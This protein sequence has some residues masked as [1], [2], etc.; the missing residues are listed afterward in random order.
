MSE[1]RP[2]LAVEGI[3]K[4]FPGVQA[5]RD[6][7]FDVFPGEILG[8]VGENGAGKSTLMRILSGVYQPDTG[9]IRF[10]GK[11]VRIQS[12]AQAQRLGISMVYQDTRL[13]SDLDIVQNV[14]LGNEP[15][16]FLGLINRTELDH[17]TIA[18][19]RQLGVSL[20]P[21]K[22][23]SGLS[24]AER[25]IVELARALK[26]EASVLILD[27]PTSALD[28]AEVERLFSILRELRHN[29]TGI[30]FISHRLQEVEELTDR[31]TVLR[32]GE[33]V[34]TLPTSSTAQEQLVGLMV[35]Q[36]E[37]SVAFPAKDTEKGSV[38]L[39]VR[40]LTSP[41]LFESISFNVSRGEIVGFGGI[42][43]EGQRDIIRALFGL[44]PATGN[45]YVDGEPVSLRGPA[46]AIS[47]GIVYLS[48]DRR[49]ESLMMPHSI[50]E[51]VVLPH[52]HAWSRAGV[53]DAKREREAVAATI[54]RLRI[55]TPSAEQPVELL[56]GGNQQKVVI[57]RWLH[58]APLVYIFDE[59]TQGVDVGT[60]LELYR[61]IRQLAEDG[62]AVLFLSSE[63]T[64]LLGVCD[65]IVVVADGR[66]VNTVVSDDAVEEEIIGSAVTATRQDVVRDETH[67]IGTAGRASGAEWILRRWGSPLF[68]VLLI[69]GL[70]V[71]TQFRS[72]YFLTSSNLSD[73]AIQVVPLA[74]VAMGQ[75]AVI[76]VGGIDLAV[77]PTMSLTT[78]I[79]SHW[80]V[81]E[82][83]GSILLGTLACVLA[84]AAVGLA[85]GLLIHY[86]R[87]P[88][89]LATLATYSVVFGLALVVRPSPGGLVSF[90]F[91]D[92]VTQRVHWI[93]IIALVTLL[94]YVVGEVVLVQTRPGIALY[95]TGSTPEA[96]F[97]AGVPVERVR[98]ASYVFCGL[99][100]ALAGLVIAARI[101][102]GDPQSG[103]SFTLASITAVVVGGTSIFGGRGTLV[104]TLAGSI[105]V[106]E[107]QNALNHLNVSAY[108]Q[109]IWTGALTLLAVVTYSVHEQGVDLH[110]LRLL[111]RWGV[112][113]SKAEG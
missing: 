39:K 95:A 53:V 58:S 40:D 10:R 5:L 63:A 26:N 37:I 69:L 92:R 44:V 33:V 8:L 56:S 7:S 54:E 28:A 66:I 65:R 110:R 103:T 109:Y 52:L 81:S 97:V 34:A 22:L 85:N 100:A 71:I 15:V 98:V 96:A 72:Q 112:P 79:A 82:A 12:P 80:I 50:R 70:G 20:N 13:V 16:G 106:L 19:L 25:Q 104:G 43:G 64:E 84:G 6:I 42:E 48:N 57:G 113:P 41:G 45:V 94:F 23:V 35:G 27:E 29:G 30:I 99:M 86:G 105:L 67:S 24:V 60:K 49:G 87:I 91:M 32:D 18:L 11:P 59:P 102:S 77:G 51:N 3:N 88:D 61:L 46:G 93:P 62:A 90:S 101:G 4:G 75:M 14:W 38:R 107:M 2:L 78:V 83:T 9:I 74:L 108:Y 111:W 36:Q 1:N 21:R 17:E 47:E 89:L 31:V 55:R 76:L 73:L 68:V